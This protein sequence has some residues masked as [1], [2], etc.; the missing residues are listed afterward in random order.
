MYAFAL[1]VVS[2]LSA[3]ASAATCVSAT[4]ASTG[5]NSSSLIVTDYTPATAPISSTD[6]DIDPTFQATYAFNSTMV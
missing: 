1:L 3:T 2:A 4:T 6:Y 5:T